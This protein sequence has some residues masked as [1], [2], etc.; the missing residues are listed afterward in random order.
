MSPDLDRVAVE[1]LDGAIRLT[2]PCTASGSAPVIGDFSTTVTASQRLS[3]TL[4]EAATSIS[5]EPA[6]ELC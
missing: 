5:L 6:G 2:L 3:S 1:L 4:D